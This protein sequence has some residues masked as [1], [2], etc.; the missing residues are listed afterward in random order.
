MHPK[1]RNKVQIS[2]SK[3]LKYI[4]GAILQWPKKYSKKHLKI[5]AAPM[6]QRHDSLT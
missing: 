2:A 1:Q 3:S 6:S 4:T 5:A